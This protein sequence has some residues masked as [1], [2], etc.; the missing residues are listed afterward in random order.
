VIYLKV[1]VNVYT[2][3]LTE[4][5]VLITFKQPDFPHLSNYRAEDSKIELN[6]A[7]PGQPMFYSLDNGSTWTQYTHPIDAMK[8]K[9]TLFCS[10]Y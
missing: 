10:R 9:D 8:D 5:K 3:L 7:Y 2:L 6:A 4:F 1:L